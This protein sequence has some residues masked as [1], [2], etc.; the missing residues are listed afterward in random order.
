MVELNEDADLDGV[1]DDPEAGNGKLVGFPQVMVVQVA[2]DA[3]TECRQATRAH[4]KSVQGH[5]P[6]MAADRLAHQPPPPDGDRIHPGGWRICEPQ[7]PLDF[8]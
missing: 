3:K 4:R 8:Q 2:T 5:T 7:L 1:H 6:H